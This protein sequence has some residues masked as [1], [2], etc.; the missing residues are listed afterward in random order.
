MVQDITP[1]KIKK[2]ILRQTVT[3]CNRLKVVAISAEAT[4]AR[5][6]TTGAESA[7]R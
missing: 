6:C 4:G 2:I 7:P 5:M 1:K 3:I